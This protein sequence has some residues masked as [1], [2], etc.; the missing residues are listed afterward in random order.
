MVG[1][2]YHQMIYPLILCLT[3]LEM[4]CEERLFIF[5]KVDCFDLTPMFRE[6]ST[7]GST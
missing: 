6:S 5:E 4:L 7:K 1:F 2:K 3:A